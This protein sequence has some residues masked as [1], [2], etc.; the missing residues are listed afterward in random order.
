M[1]TQVARVFI[2]APSQTL[3]HRYLRHKVLRNFFPNYLAAVPGLDQ[4]CTRKKVRGVRASPELRNCRQ[5]AGM[6]CRLLAHTC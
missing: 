4:L 2:H 5:A 3:V 1:A 6:L